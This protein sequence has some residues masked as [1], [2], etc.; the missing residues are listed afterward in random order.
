MEDLERLREHLGT[1]LLRWKVQPIALVLG[2]VI[3][4]SD[5]EDDP[6]T[7][8]MIES[9]GHLRE[10]GRVPERVRQY[11]VA[12]FDLVRHHCKGTQD[13]PALEAVVVQVA[14]ERYQVIPDE[15]GVE[16]GAIGQLPDP[17][18]LVPG[19]VL[20]PV[21]I[22]NFIRFFMARIFPYRAYV[23]E[24]AAMELSTLV[25]ASEKTAST[26]KRT[27]K[28]DALAAVFRDVGVDEA[29]I[30][31]GYLRGRPPQGKIGTGWATLQAVEVAAA[32]ESHADSRRG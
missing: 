4:G 19:H 5:A 3:A 18:H 22:P 1:F 31:A 16:A 9:G 10:D 25:A 7:G 6:A 20:G 23:G 11:E 2:R 28:I 8:R 27:E 24:N 15:A 32:G 26:S 13:R 17:A 29:A 12:D 30:A 21:K 14:K